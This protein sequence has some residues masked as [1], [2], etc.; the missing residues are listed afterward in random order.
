LRGTPEQAAGVKQ[1]LDSI[2]SAFEQDKANKEPTWREKL[3][4]EGSYDDF[5]NP[6][7]DA[8]EYDRRHPGMF[9]GK[10]P[11]GYQEWL[12]AHGK[13]STGRP[14]NG[15][16][17]SA[18]PAPSGKSDFFAG[19]D[20]ERGGTFAEKNPGAKTEGA[21]SAT[22][23]QPEMMNQIAGVIAPAAAK[24]A[25]EMN[26]TGVNSPEKAETWLKAKFHDDPDLDR[27][28]A[29]AK[30]TYDQITKLNN[31]PPSVVQFIGAILV[32]LAGGSPQVIQAILHPH[33][34]LNAERERTAGEALLKMQLA[35]VNSKEKQFEMAQK[36]GE[37][38]MAQKRL[39]QQNDIFQQRETDTANRDKM[40]MNREGLEQGRAHA[41]SMS[42]KYSEDA[43]HAT[44]EQ[45]KHFMDLS[46]QYRQHAE[47]FGN[48]LGE[49]KLPKVAPR[50]Q[51][52][53][54]GGPQSN[55]GE[56]SPSVSRLLGMSNA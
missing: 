50:P 24:L 47:T 29:E 34:H 20:K 54:P 13:D 37:N 31:Q 25:K 17:A 49:P 14:Q 3:G 1:G 51:P 6:K 22:I 19:L 45:R 12:D 30:A 8:A 38:S 16:E 11:S 15:P 39:D 43:T 44:G 41:R 40:K 55:A 23:G 5:L 10:T 28:I 56:V 2:L 48:L 21:Y 4:T 52:K 26:N 18:A 36:T 7:V 32:G 53:L 35:K 46:E 27:A 42:Q 9:S 33:E